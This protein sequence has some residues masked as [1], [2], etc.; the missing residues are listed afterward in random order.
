MV[1]CREGRIALVVVAPAGDHDR[2]SGRVEGRYRRY[3]SFRIGRIRVSQGVSVASAGRGKDY[4]LVL[5]VCVLTGRYQISAGVE[6]HGADAVLHGKAAEVAHAVLVVSVYI[7][8]VMARV[9]AYVDQL[10]AVLHVYL[11]GAGEGVLLTIQLND[12]LYAHR[13]KLGGVRSEF[14]L[15]S[16]A[17]AGSDA[18][19][20]GRVLLHA[21]HR[22]HH[23]LGSGSAGLGVK[24][25]R[26]DG[27]LLAGH[28][29]GRV[30]GDGVDAELEHFADPN[31]RG[32][33]QVAVCLRYADEVV[34]VISRNSGTQLAA[35]RDAVP[36]V[37]HSAGV[38]HYLDLGYG[39][40]VIRI[41]DRDLDVDVLAHCVRAQL[42][43][44][45][46]AVQ[47]V[48]YLK[49]LVL[50]GVEAALPDGI[51]QPLLGERVRVD[52]VPGVVGVAPAALVV[53]LVVGRGNVPA[54]VKGHYVLLIARV[55]AAGPYLA[56]AVADL[57]ELDIAVEHRGVVGEVRE[58][59]EGRTRVV[60]LVYGLNI[61]SS[62]IN[63]KL[64]IGLKPRVTCFV[65]QRLVVARDYTRGVEG[66][67]MA[68]PARPS[69]LVARQCYP[70]GAAR[71][72]VVYCVVV[73]RP[74]IGAFGGHLRRV[75][76][77]LRRVR[78]TGGVK[79]VRVVGEGH[80]VNVVALG[81]TF[82]IIES[83]VQ[84]ARTVG[85]F[86]GVRV[87]LA[88]VRS[89]LGLANGEAPGLCSVLVVSSLDRHHDG[90][91]AVGQ[92]R[93]RGI[94]N[95]AVLI[96]RIDSLTVYGHGHDRVLST[97]FNLRA[98]SG[99][100]VI[101]SL[102]ALSRR[103]LSDDRLVLHRDLFAAADILALRVRAA[104]R[105]CDLLAGHEVCG[106]G[107][108][109]VLALVERS[110]SDLDGERV[111]AKHSV[112]FDSELV[113]H[114]RISV[115]AGDGHRGLVD[116]SG[117]QA[118][119]IICAGVEEKLVYV[120]VRGVVRTVGLVGVAV[121]LEVLG[122][123]VEL[124][125][126]A[127][128]VEAALLAVCELPVGVFARGLRV[129]GVVARAV[130]TQVAVG[131]VLEAVPVPVF[132]NGEH[133]AAVFGSGLAIRNC[134]Q[135]ICDRRAVRRA[136][137]PRQHALSG[138]IVEHD[139]VAGLRQIAALAAGLG[140][141]VNLDEL[142]RVDALIVRLILVC[143]KLAVLAIPFDVKSGSSRV[144]YVVAALCRCRTYS[145]GVI[146]LVK[147]QAIIFCIYRQLLFT[148]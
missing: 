61:I 97:V 75:I 114:S 126:P 31:R 123:A 57:D 11:Y 83:L 102:G 52:D 3:F 14:E 53:I 7:L 54:L 10:G 128:E 87:E 33:G 56:L 44:H 143:R 24:E 93:G 85:I 62:S 122:V 16:L 70:V 133:Y 96:L 90:D 112:D 140:R 144:Y 6:L 124:C 58:V 55:V 141:P 105:Y 80:K 2:A 15:N 119:R 28:G 95:R 130:G 34:A 8:V 35:G 135:G 49:V 47:G 132:L 30:A 120:V 109:A 45:H 12:S 147:R 41:V 74:L 46:V 125:R 131:L 19:V 84:R 129:E 21:V 9:N 94:G 13:L 99:A 107:V 20:F 29:V 68:R 38:H 82:H 60:E 148:V 5:A 72:E 39:V 26:G 100:L 89:E 43:A 106:H 86:T 59:A 103:D 22:E 18:D 71:V 65:V 69:H 79:V 36:G 1:C 25:V 63:K 113:G 115:C 40:A 76:Q 66:V 145:P 67:Y 111:H 50:G 127:L 146:H 134:R 48:A 121:I 108:D 51:K 138:D 73:C 98:D 77:R 23:A 137:L 32:D 17:C 136:Y 4:R 64:V 78:S 139:L 110:F 91:T 42:A 81:D 142:H 104:D 117:S 101:A 27:Q 88:E 118:C 37:G 92:V 116:N